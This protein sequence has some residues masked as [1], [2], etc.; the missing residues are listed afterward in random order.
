MNPRTTCI[1]GITSCTYPE[2]NTGNVKVCGNKCPIGLTSLYEGN[3]GLGASWTISGGLTNNNNIINFMSTCLANKTLNLS[4]SE[5][6]VI[7]I[8]MLVILLIIFCHVWMF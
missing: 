7:R 3:P 6:N 5:R 1:G 8:S 4:S 2:Q